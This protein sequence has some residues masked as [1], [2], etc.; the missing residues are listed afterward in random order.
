MLGILKKYFPDVD[1]TPSCQR[2]CQCLCQLSTSCFI[3]SEICC[4][5]ISMHR[6]YILFKDFCQDEV[7]YV[8]T[9]Q[10]IS[11]CN[12]LTSFYVLQDFTK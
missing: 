7:S 4:C 5:T 8:E 11:S 10:F 6:Y 1:L 3:L 12:Q 9:N 2:L